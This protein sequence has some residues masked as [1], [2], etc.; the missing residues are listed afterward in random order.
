MAMGDGLNYVIPHSNLV[1]FSAHELETILSGQAE[2]DIEFI[3]SRT[4][5]EMYSPEH[6]IVKWFWEVLEDFSQV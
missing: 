2:V 3:R 4:T 6:P 5:Y 1:S